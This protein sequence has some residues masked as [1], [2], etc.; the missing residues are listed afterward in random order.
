VEKLYLSITVGSGKAFAFEVKKGDKI[1]V[2]K[3][4]FLV[5]I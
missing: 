1:K 4:I 5:L 3:R 2:G